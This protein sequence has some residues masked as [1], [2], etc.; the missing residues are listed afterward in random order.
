MED[1]H[2]VRSLTWQEVLQG[3]R[4]V[5]STL[6]QRGLKYVHL[7][8][9]GRGSCRSAERGGR[10]AGRSSR[11]NSVKTPKREGAPKPRA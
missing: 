4:A 3:C 5:P 11:G 8:R 2:S 10:E 6:R 7:G 9:Q 1:R